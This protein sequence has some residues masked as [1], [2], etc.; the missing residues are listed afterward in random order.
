MLN[1]LIL[2]V[3][4]T[5]RSSLAPWHALKRAM[6]CFLE[7]WVIQKKINNVFGCMRSKG[8]SS[9]EYIEKESNRSSKLFLYS[10]RMDEV[11]VEVDNGG[12]EATTRLSSEGISTNG[13]CLW[14]TFYDIP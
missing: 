14:Q 8:I 5:A 13:L 6:T 3:F 1:K 11:A 7:P 12:N 4:V 10:S 2:D 9:N